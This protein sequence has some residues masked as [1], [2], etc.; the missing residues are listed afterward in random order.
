MKKNKLWTDFVALAWCYNSLIEGDT[1]R[2]EDA[3]RILKKY[4]LVDKDGFWKGE[5]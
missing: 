5:E 3:Y 1:H 4:N 2:I